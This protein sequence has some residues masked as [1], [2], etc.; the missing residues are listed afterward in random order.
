LD[1][2]A[3]VRRLTGEG[4]ITRIRL[5]PIKGTEIIRDYSTNKLLYFISCNGKEYHHKPGDCD[6]ITSFRSEVAVNVKNGAKLR[7]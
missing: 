1:D 7:L 3:V 2:K 4:A 6:L 5:F